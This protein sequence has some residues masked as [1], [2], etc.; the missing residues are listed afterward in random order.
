MLF[1]RFASLALRS[2]V[3]L[4]FSALLA[5]CASEGS[6]GSNDNSAPVA[7]AGPGSRHGSRA[8]AGNRIEAANATPP[9]MVLP[10]SIAF[11]QAGNLY[12]ADTP[13]NRILRIDA[14]GRT[15]TCAGTGR[16]GYSG[17]GGPAV[18]AELSTPCAVAVDSSGSVYFAD[19]SNN[20]VR[21]IDS[22]GTISTIAGSG[23]KGD[24]GDGGPATSA[25]LSA[26]T[27]LAFDRDGNLIIL[28][29]G[30]GRL[31]MI[32]SDGTMKAVAAVFSSSNLPSD[33]PARV[34]TGP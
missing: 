5:S 19:S 10:Q 11:D 14:S 2:V 26:P 1:I 33:V 16:K 13:R 17:D 21:K 27:G 34:P 32:A 30:N 3:I 4:T 12:V 31:R 9:A 29:S 23:G 22:S 20:V 25:S 6:G 15:T 7:R 8:H 28:D 24:W 18:S